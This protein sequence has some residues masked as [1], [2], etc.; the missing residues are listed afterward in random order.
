VLILDIMGIVESVTDVNAE[1]VAPAIVTVEFT[2]VGTSTGPGTDVGDVALAVVVGA[3]ADVIVVG[4]SS[5]AE[6]VL[7]AETRVLLKTAVWEFVCVAERS[8][9]LEVAGVAE[10]EEVAS[11]DVGSEC[12]AVVVE[13]ESTVVIDATGV[14][15]FRLDPVATTTATDV[16]TSVV[17]TAGTL[18]WV[19]GVGST[20]VE[21][22]HQEVTTVID[23]FAFVAVALG[24]ADWI[25]PAGP[26]V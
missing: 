16:F 7:A 5:S 20:A 25:D 15:V 2:A 21:L 24:E 12:T 17:M 26:A 19:G 1:G 3:G 23:V 6:V 9:V 18:D 8:D 11:A 4:L 14:E 22:L 10:R 13:F